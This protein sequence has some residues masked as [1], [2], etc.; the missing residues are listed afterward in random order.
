MCNLLGDTGG[1]KYA[2]D[3][4]TTT[5]ISIYT[6]SLRSRIGMRVVPEYRENAGIGGVG[7]SAY[8]RGLVGECSPL[9]ASESACWPSGSIYIKKKPQISLPTKQTKANLVSQGGGRV[10]RA[11][12]DSFSRVAR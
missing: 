10:N 1:A 11:I 4:L 7:S 9:R 6:T 5:K 12:Y 3:I 2:R 8:L